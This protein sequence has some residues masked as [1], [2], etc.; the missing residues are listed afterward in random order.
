[1]AARFLSTISYTGT[2]IT[3]KVNTSAMHT[4]KI[5]IVLDQCAGRLSVTISCV[6][7]P[8]PMYPIYI[9][10]QLIVSISVT[11]FSFPFPLLR[12]C[13]GSKDKTMTVL[14]YTKVQH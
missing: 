9:P 4:A 12:Y 8:Y 7:G 3:G 10:T 2:I 11:T 6:L 5:I 1:L 14:L 13:S